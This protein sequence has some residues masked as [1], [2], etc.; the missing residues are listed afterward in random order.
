MKKVVL[1]VLL[2]SILVA[3]T[4]FAQHP[5]GLGIGITGGGGFH[6]SDKV[7][8][9]GDRV[10]GSTGLS[11]K[12]PALPIYWGLKFNFSLGFFRM[13]LL[14]DYYIFDN[15]IT[16]G[17][18]FNLGWYLGAGGYFSFLNAYVSGFSLGLRIPAGLDLTLLDN[19]LDIFFEIAPSFGIGFYPKGAE[20][21]F[22]DGGMA[23][24]LGGRIWF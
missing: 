4:V 22:F 20:V 3:G 14:G 18:G 21:A 16:S 24:T 5:D 1:A 13:D 8:S 15:A 6:W 10:H 2:G 9:W 17:S 7:Q 19:K 23:F 12:V 11:L